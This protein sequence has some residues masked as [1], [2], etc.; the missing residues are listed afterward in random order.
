[1]PVYT[2]NLYW[3][4]P[5]MYLLVD[6]SSVIT[7]CLSCDCICLMYMRS[8]TSYTYV[9]N[10]DKHVTSSNEKYIKK[11]SLWTAFSK[12][13][14]RNTSGQLQHTCIK[15]PAFST[16]FWIGYLLGGIGWMTATCRK[17]LWGLWTWF[18]EGWNPTTQHSHCIQANDMQQKKC[19]LHDNTLSSANYVMIHCCSK[20][21]YVGLCARKCVTLRKVLIEIKWFQGSTSMVWDIFPTEQVNSFVNWWP[22]L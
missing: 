7:V 6:L 12:P 16:R 4:T 22:L 20:P 2:C 5:Y 8:H 19:E 18:W 21:M 15:N 14:P 17:I 9:D 13:S 3:G 10:I 11:Y 1:M